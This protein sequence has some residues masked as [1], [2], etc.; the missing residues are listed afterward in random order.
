MQHLNP[1][2]NSTK[3]AILTG[4]TATGKSS[5][6][7]NWATENP[8]VELINADSLLVYRGL[9]IG[10]AKPT[11]AELQQVPHHLVNICNPDESFT[12][13]EFVRATELAIETIYKKGKKPLIVGGTGFYL[14]SLLFG[15]WKVPASDPDVKK[16]LSEKENPELFQTLQKI[17]PVSAQ[18]IGSS[19][20]YRLIRFLEIFELTGKTPVELQAEHPTTPDPRFQLWI[21]DRENSELFSRIEQR[22]QK[23]LEDG[24]IDE[25]K[26]IQNQ[27]PDCRPLKSVGYAQVHT[28]LEGLEVPG[29]KPKPG[30]EGLSEEI[31][32]AT[33]QLVKSQRTWFKGQETRV[34]ETKRWI[35]DSDLEKLKMELNSVYFGDN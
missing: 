30:L 23:M 32:L 8:E 11:E 24:L 22:T 31:Q 20:R 4:P 27:Y 29:R 17:D 6:A 5:I 1:K 9:N 33:R 19:D 28:F 21:V 26:K 14:N 34:P 3:I 2:L 7:L 35:L 15:I 13:G 10:T 16:R 12:A 25:F 18:K